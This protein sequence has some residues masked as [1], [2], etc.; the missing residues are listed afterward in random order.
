M[1]KIESIISWCLSQAFLALICYILYIVFL[2]NSFNIDL[3]YMQWLSMIIIFQCII[4][5]NKKE[6]NKPD[7]GKF[8]PD[9]NKI[10]KN[11]K[12]GRI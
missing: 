10:G 8:I 11:F 6:D 3:G 1:K 4:P 12:N 2:A 9:V 5:K 7:L